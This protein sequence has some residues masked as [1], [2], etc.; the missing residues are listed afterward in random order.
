MRIEI[1]GDNCRTCQRLKSNIESALQGRD[2]RIELL[3]ICEPQRFA[4]YGLLSLPGLLIDGE[5]K[6][7][8][9]LLSQQEVLSLLKAS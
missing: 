6:S 9:R 1:L 2:T 5:L 7:A 8:G 4:E 3:N